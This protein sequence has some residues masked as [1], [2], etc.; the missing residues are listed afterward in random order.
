VKKKQAKEPQ[1][2]VG[3]GRLLNVVGVFLLSSQLMNEIQSICMLSAHS[4]VYF[5]LLKT[6]CGIAKYSQ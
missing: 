4:T 1:S 5:C 6:T 3:M 2:K